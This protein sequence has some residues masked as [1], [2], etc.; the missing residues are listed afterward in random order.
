[1]VVPV[2][3]LTDRSPV[4]SYGLTMVVRPDRVIEIGKILCNMLYLYTMDITGSPNR[5]SCI[6]CDRL[7]E[8]D[9]GFIAHFNGEYFIDITICL[10]YYDSQDDS[11]KNQECKVGGW[12]YLIKKNG[13]N[14]VIVT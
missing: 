13:N 6:Y 2:E 10:D 8:V 3:C 1:M 12:I 4:A 14:Y 11:I 7:Y 9:E 5:M